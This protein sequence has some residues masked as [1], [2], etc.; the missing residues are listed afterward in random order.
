ME[1]KNTELGADTRPQ[2]TFVRNKNL[3]NVTKTKPLI[4]SAFHFGCSVIL[5]KT[6]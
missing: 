4:I 6:M 2:V 3:Q 1:F 5:M